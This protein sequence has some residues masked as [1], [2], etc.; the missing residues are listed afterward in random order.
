[1]MLRQ[2][3]PLAACIAI[4]S[5]S[6]LGDCDAAAGKKQYNKCV[7]CHSTEA[8][9]HLMGP[10]LHDIVG[11]QVGSAEGFVYS[12]VMADSDE[13]WSVDL[14]DKFLQNPSDVMPGT[15][16]PF[17]GIRKAD[18]REALICFMK[19]LGKAT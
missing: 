15:V 5:A 9:E 3:I 16:M 18:Q 17:G 4:F 19:T 8:G 7:A 2:I 12:Q 10:S 1:M 11:R 13:V 14:L 6:A